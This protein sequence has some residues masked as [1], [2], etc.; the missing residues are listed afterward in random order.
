METVYVIGAFIVVVILYA[1]LITR[2]RERWCAREGFEDLGK[3]SDEWYQRLRT[4]QQ[5]FGAG[6][7][8]H[9][10]SALRRVIDGR[11]LWL[12]EHEWRTGSLSSRQTTWKTFVIWELGETGLPDFT[13]CRRSPFVM[14]ALANV[15]RAILFLP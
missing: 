7:I 14:S 6:D 13:L 8:G 11:T 10:G 5:C 15:I 12:L 3:V 4:H 9:V 1:M 2:Y